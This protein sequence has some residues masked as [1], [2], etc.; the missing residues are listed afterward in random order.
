[1]FT[2]NRL[3]RPSTPPLGWP[4]HQKPSIKSCHCSQAHQSGSVASE[5]ILI[6]ETTGQPGHHFRA[7]S[8]PCTPIDT[9]HNQL[10]PLDSTQEF[11]RM[12]KIGIWRLVRPSIVIHVWARPVF[13]LAW[14]SHVGVVRVPPGLV[15]HVVRVLPGLVVVHV[16]RVLPGL[17]VV[18]VVRV[19]PGVLQA[20]VVRVLPG[21]RCCSCA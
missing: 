17:V 18:H 6:Q 10:L 19:L 2:T 14:G 13:N 15:V 9:L 4:S 12:F 5:R 11:S 20:G 8:Q 7:L 16:V 1:M 3:D 21:L